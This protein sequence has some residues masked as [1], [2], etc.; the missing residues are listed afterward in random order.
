MVEQGI[1]AGCAGGG[2]ENICA[3]ADILK[4]SSIGSDSFTLSV[5]PASMPVYM[6]L[7]KNGCAATILETGAVMKTAGSQLPVVAF[8]P[9]DFI[10]VLNLLVCLPDG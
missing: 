8:S 10:E 9:V 7:V 3:A 5:Y 4:G 2:F 1:I 6:E